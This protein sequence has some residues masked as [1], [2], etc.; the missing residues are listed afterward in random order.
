MHWC[1]HEITGRFVVV[2]PIQ[3]GSR[4]MVTAESRVSFPVEV[5]F[6]FTTWAWVQATAEMAISGGGHC[7]SPFQLWLFFLPLICIHKQTIKNLV[8]H[9]W[10]HCQSPFRQWP[11]LKLRWW[12][13]TLSRL[14]RINLNHC[15]MA[16]RSFF[17]PQSKK[18][19][20][21]WNQEYM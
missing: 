21:K 8:S 5:E 12:T 4:F 6:E 3:G 9:C 2:M 13:Q 14:Y 20:W 11:E 15:N 10:N 18:G 17:A 19:K 1:V 16:Q 7:W